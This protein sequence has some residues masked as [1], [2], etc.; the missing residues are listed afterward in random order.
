MQ[1]ERTDEEGHDAARGINHRRVRPEQHGDEAG[2]HRRIKAGE[3][4]GRDEAFA[5]RGQGK[6]PVTHA[7][8]DGQHCGGNP[9]QDVAA[10]VT[11]P[12][13]FG[14]RDDRFGMRARRVRLIRQAVPPLLCGCFHNRFPQ[15]SQANNV[16]KHRAANGLRYRG[17]SPGSRESSSSG[18]R[19]AG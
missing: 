17:M 4:R 14:G 13:D 1:H 11:Q 18:A 7:D 6:Q 9:A 15:F 10:Q 2:Q 12:G 5:Q 3:D 16:P 8:R 19:I